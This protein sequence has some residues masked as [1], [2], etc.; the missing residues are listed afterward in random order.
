ML[1]EQVLR[2]S[3][4]INRYP[5][6]ENE[7]QQELRRQRE[8]SA[9][10]LVSLRKMRAENKRANCEDGI[11]PHVAGGTTCTLLDE[12][13]EL[14]VAVAEKEDNVGGSPSRGQPRNGYIDDCMDV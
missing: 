4:R 7:Q 10:A 5:K 8:S 12:P 3:S 11:S 6:D 13:M 14:A 1:C 9:W 2:F